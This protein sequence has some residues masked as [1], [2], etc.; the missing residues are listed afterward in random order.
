MFYGVNHNCVCER[1]DL[2]RLGRRPICREENP[3]ELDEI[4]ENF[5]VVC[6]INCDDT[7]RAIRDWI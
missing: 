2:N 4:Y 6:R 7:L 3:L 1:E 5:V